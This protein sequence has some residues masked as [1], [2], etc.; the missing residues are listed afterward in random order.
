MGTEHGIY[1]R[2]KKQIQ[3]FG[4]KIWGEK[5]TWKIGV[6]LKEVSKMDET[7]QQ[8]VKWIHLHHDREQCEHRVMKFWAP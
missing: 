7:V 8:I 3:S 1:D 5:P 4:R 2:Q 6:Q